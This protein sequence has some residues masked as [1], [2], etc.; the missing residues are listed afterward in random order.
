MTAST[1]CRFTYRIECRLG[2]WLAWSWYDW[3]RKIDCTGHVRI[4][5]LMVLADNYELFF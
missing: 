3:I 5:L 4:L 1:F 2:R